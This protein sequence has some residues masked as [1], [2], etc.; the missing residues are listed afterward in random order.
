M[1]ISH[2]IARDCRFDMNP[3][4]ILTTGAGGFVGRHMLERLALCYPAAE[5]QQIGADITNAQTL[6]AEIRDLRPQVCIHLAAVSAVG[7]ADRDTDRAWAV[8]LQGTLNLASSLRRHAAG[9]LFLFA[10]TAEAYGA[11][12]RTG[13]PLDE[14]SPLAPLN[15]YGATKAAADLA[16]GAMT[17]ADLHCIRIR[18]FN[19]TGTGQSDSF[20]VAS[21]ARQVA[22]IAAGLSPPV[23]KVGNLE[24]RRDFL[25]VRD[26]CAVYT[27]C[28]EHAQT[29]PKN[30]IMNVASGAARRIGDVLDSLLSAAKLATVSI[31]Q[32]TGRIRSSDIPFAAGNSDYAQRLLNWTPAITWEQTISDV[33]QDWR[34]RIQAP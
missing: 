17:G 12:F 5:L 14:T 23:L 18:A 22:L 25:D 34:E 27:A 8:N 2:D 24:A 1:P 4:R 33:L 7:E 30:A 9:S 28:I 3:T 21:F 29:L 10:S 20:V 31:E 11:S 15:T 13:M 16:L 19:H 32:D 26:V 6:D